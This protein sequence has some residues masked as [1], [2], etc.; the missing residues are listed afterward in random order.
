MT[1]FTDLLDSEKPIEPDPIKQA[2]DEGKVFRAGSIDFPSVGIEKLHLELTRLHGDRDDVKKLDVVYHPD[3]GKYAISMDGGDT[4]N[5]KSEEDVVSAL[6][7]AMAGYPDAVEE[8]PANPDEKP[9]ETVEDIPEP[10][11]AEESEK[12]KT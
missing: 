6:N 11:A 5:D 9:A 8:K 7:D 1:T 12:P 2:A 10:V 3:S 4:Y